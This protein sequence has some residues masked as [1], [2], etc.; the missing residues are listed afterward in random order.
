MPGLLCELVHRV[1]VIKLDKAEPALA[2]SDLVHQLLDLGDRSECA[3]IFLHGFIVDV[4]FETSDKNF[5]NGFA[6][7]AAGCTRGRIFPGCSAFRF[8]FG[9]VEGVRSVILYLVDHVHRA[10]SHET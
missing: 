7:R 10:V 9:S 1:V 3:E 2:S 6:T 8:N 4:I 5:F